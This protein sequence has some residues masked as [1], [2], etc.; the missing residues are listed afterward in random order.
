[1]A[2]ESKNEHPLIVDL[3]SRTITVPEELKYIGVETDN[4]SEKV[5]FKVPRYFDEPDVQGQGDLLSKVA[6]VHFLNAG[7]S[8]GVYNIGEKKDNEDGTISLAWLVGKD[9]T[10]FAGNVKFQLVFT[11]FDNGNNVYKLSTTPATLIV[12][13]GID[14]K[15][16]S[17]SKDSETYDQL[18]E[19]IYNGY[20]TL[21]AVD[22]ET[23]KNLSASPKST[24]SSLETS[25]FANLDAGLYL[26][27]PENV[28]D[29]YY[30]YVVYW[31]GIKVSDPIVKYLTTTFSN[32]CI[33]TIHLKN[34]SVTH[35]KLADNSVDANNIV[36]GAVTQG[37]IADG[38]I[39]NTK[40]SD[41]AI[42]MDK[43]T[44]AR[45][46]HSDG[47]EYG[48]TDAVDALVY[49][50][51]GVDK[52]GVLSNGV[53]V[54]RKTISRSVTDN[55]K[56]LGYVSDL[57][58]D[59]HTYAVTILGVNLYM[60][61]PIT[62]E[63]AGVIVPLNYNYS[64]ESYW[65]GVAGENVSSSTDIVYLNGIVCEQ[66]GVYK[67]KAANG[68][69]WLLAGTIVFAATDEVVSLM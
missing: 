37:K 36:D 6:Q 22:T 62:S 25:A 69:S 47:Y 56:T 66:D 65:D 8:Y 5:W 32:A 24:I 31:N 18:I 2:I 44:N 60:I 17:I 12:R 20:E 30:G 52:I 13:A 33:E 46:R 41:N 19:L 7:G 14:T 63:D 27:T 9:V 21:K 1:M 54:Y 64:Y 38:S 53:P 10:A 35:E 49:N 29:E 48:V 45:Y 4:N 26:Y 11:L 34:G 16:F 15:N 58:S 55:E 40:L 67:I 39:T 61:S 42:T 28:E 51:N 50:I 43:L 68:E 23:L 57:L 3:T 59:Y